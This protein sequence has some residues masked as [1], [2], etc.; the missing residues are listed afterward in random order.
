M[1]G[2][3]MYDFSLKP[4]L[5]ASRRLIGAEREPLLLIDGLV[6]R[7]DALVDYAAREVE[8]RPAWSAGGGYPGLRAPAPLDYVR[9]VVLAVKPIMEEAFGLAGMRLARA[10][11]NFSLVTLSP[12]RLAPTQRIPH[13]DTADPL[14][15]AFLH[16][17][18]DEKFGGTAFYR[19]RSTGFETISEER[20]PAY[21]AACAREFGGAPPPQ[22][23]VAA[24]TNRFEQIGQVDAR[25]DRLIIYRSRLLHSGQIARP[26][27]LSADPR[28]GRLTA[29]IFVNYRADPER[30]SSASSLP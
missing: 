21:D 27:L 7:P 15:F 25:F 20:V 24:G 17:L 18:C 8:F 3:P 16:Y 2:E 22:T 11:C 29:N 9:A 28:K 10:E 30:G 6:E 13:V 26:D 12:E 5:R 4:K 23:Y 1:A 14:Q 19:H